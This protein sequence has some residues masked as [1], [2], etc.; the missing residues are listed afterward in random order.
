MRF[1]KSCG[2]I[3]YRFDKKRVL[4][5]IVRYSAYSRYWGLV[6]G[7]VEA[8]ETELQTAKREVYEEVGFQNIQIASGFRETN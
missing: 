5:L 8:E 2:V 1:E 6:K 7:H 3:I 4:Y